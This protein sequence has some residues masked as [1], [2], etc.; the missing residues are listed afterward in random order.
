MKREIQFKDYCI[1]VYMEEDFY[2]E[3]SDAK[4][5]EVWHSE[6]CFS[7][8]EV[9]DQVDEAL[10]WHFEAYKGRKDADRER[11]KKEVFDLAMLMAN[12]GARESDR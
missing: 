5:G 3:I 6:P 8:L 11:I 4:T 10:L 1:A 9:S 2:V 7:A 12:P